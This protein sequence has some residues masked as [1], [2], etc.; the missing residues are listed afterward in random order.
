MSRT[1][2]RLFTLLLAAAFM[3]FTLSAQES[4]FEKVVSIFETN[5]SSPYCH[6]GS[7][8]LNL[9][10]DA[11]AIFNSLVGATPTNPAAAA[12]GNLLVDPGYPD[13][14]YLFRKV[15]NGL[16]DH[17]EAL[18]VAEGNPMPNAV[19]LSNVDTELIRQW[20]LLGAPEEGEVDDLAAIEDFYA[21][22]ALEGVEPLD[23]PAP[24]EGFQV[25]MGR[26]F[27]QPG[28]EREY[29][30][31][32][33]VPLG[34][35]LEIVGIHVRM[36]T[37]SH[38][39]A[40][41]KFIDSEAAEGQPEG[42][43][44]VDN[45]LD[46]IDYF[47]SSEFVTGGQYWE[48]IYEMPENTAYRWEDEPVLNLNYHIKNYSSLGVLPAEAYI[49][50][51]TQPRYTA[52]YAL[53]AATVSYG[54]TNEGSS[55]FD[56]Q[57]EP[58][59]TDTTFT[60]R[61]VDEESTDDLHIFMLTPHTHQLGVDYDMYLSDA[62]GNK[63]EQVLEGFYDPTHTFDQGYYD[64]TH[65]PVRLFEPLMTIKE[66]EGMIMEATYNNPT[67][68]VVT[69]GPT[70]NDEMFI[71]YV[72]YYRTPGLIDGIDAENTVLENTSLSAVPNPYQDQTSI[73]FN[74]NETADVNLRVFNSLG[75]E[76]SVLFNGTLPAGKQ[77][78]PFN[79][80]ERNLP[81]GVYVAKLTVDGQESSIKLMH[82]D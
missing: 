24:E 49:N 69:F 71:G 20:I 25:Y 8:P 35:S 80:I 66:N 14:S 57:I 78:L 74:L 70:T 81:A 77:Q 44:P 19:G 42:M 16:Y 59:A 72:I 82:V 63:G 31:K 37:Y 75:Q 52:E 32:Q 76:V 53:E 10:G 50:F 39:Y 28:E 60:M 56:L 47:L 36:N 1:F 23:P 4:T 62:D 27:L 2:S 3:P 61:W 68:E 30:K 48:T 65:P 13:N 43:V 38:H 33:I 7:N 58:N 17:T 29:L 67:D 51:Y 9:T 40:V 55:P 64:Y 45:L 22:D 54:M 73:Q 21:G 12:K 41:S 5:C 46:Q 26:V 15:N 11:N 6:G 18:E 34:D 79:A